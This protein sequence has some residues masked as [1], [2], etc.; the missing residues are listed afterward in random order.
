MKVNFFFY[1]DVQEKWRVKKLIAEVIKR[2]QLQMFQK[3]SVN[4]Q[5]AIRMIKM[6]WKSHKSNS[7]KNFESIK[8]QH[9][10]SKLFSTERIGK[11]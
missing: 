2:S 4:I 3:L 9:L 5:L 1:F 8:F 11:I 10:K 6:I 7:K